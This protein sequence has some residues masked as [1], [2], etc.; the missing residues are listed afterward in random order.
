MKTTISGYKLR[1]SLIRNVLLNNLSK[2]HYRG[3]K[4]ADEKEIE[5]QDKK[6]GG[7]LLGSI[8]WALI[9]IWAGLVFLASNLGWFSQW[10]L[11]VDQSWNFQGF[12]DW[13]TFSV[14]NLIALGAGVILL[15]E[16][17]AQ[18]LLPN[19]R[20]RAG[21]TLVLAAV[22]IGIG[23]GGWLS[24]DYLWPLVLIAVGINVLVRGVRRSRK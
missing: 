5:K 15:L 4:M 10:G 18:L 11:T 12:R 6:E 22:C 14:W 9:L 1:I 20:G 8:A 3:V 23:L 2:N 17:V 19:Y 16:A 24:W 13:T 21:G 7:D